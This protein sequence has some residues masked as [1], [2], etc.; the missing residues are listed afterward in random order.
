MA[1]KEGRAEPDARVLLR[2]KPSAEE[3]RK[4]KE[5]RTDDRSG[6]CAST[7]KEAKWGKLKNE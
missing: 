6:H 2:R 4:E 3:E 5:K 1:R 7:E